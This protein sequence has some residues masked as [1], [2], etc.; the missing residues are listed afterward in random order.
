MNQ[1]ID[2]SQFRLLWCAEKEK[3]GLLTLL[4]GFSFLDQKV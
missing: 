4:S 3:V 2:S 1:W